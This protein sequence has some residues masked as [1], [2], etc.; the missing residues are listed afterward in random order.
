M[1]TNSFALAALLSSESAKYCQNIEIE[2]HISA[3]GQVYFSSRDFNFEAI[4]VLYHGYLLEWS[5]MGAY[6]GNFWASTISLKTT[7]K[8]AYIQPAD[9]LRAH[10]AHGTAIGRLIRRTVVRSERPVVLT[11]LCLAFVWLLLG[12]F[13]LK[14]ALEPPIKS[15][16]IW[17]NLSKFWNA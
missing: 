16:K 5:D 9:W 12:V 11:G 3:F 13:S 7:V 15:G 1:A 2:S 17:K 14:L 4:L 10:A 6:F 8:A